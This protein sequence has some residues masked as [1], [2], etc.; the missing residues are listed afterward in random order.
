[1][2][3]LVQILTPVRGEP[4]VHEGPRWV[5]EGLKGRLTEISSRRAGAGLTAACELIEQVQS[6]RDVAAWVSAGD[7]AFYPPDLAERGVDLDCLP[8]VFAPGSQA[9][10]RVADRLLRSGGFGLVVVD[11]SDVSRA[12]GRSAEVP[13]ALLSRLVK[14]SQHHAASVVFLTRKSASQPSLGSLI[15]LRGEATRVRVGENRFVVRIEVIKDKRQ[16][17]G[18]KHEEVY[19][20]PDGLR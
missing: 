15:A 12:T 19:R 3:A 8:V 6:V 7:S 18:W 14:L 4:R 5:F 11:L 10:A 1:M 9:A 16:G 2:S 20:G 17:P 13:V